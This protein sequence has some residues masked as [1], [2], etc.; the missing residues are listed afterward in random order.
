MSGQMNGKI[1]TPGQDPRQAPNPLRD[2][3]RIIRTVEDTLHKDLKELCVL[4]TTLS[5]QGWI[6]GIDTAMQDSKCVLSLTQHMHRTIKDGL[7]VEHQKIIRLGVRY[8]PA[9]TLIRKAVA[10]MTSEEPQTE[11]T[12][13][14][15]A[16]ADAQD[17]QTSTSDQPNEERK[18]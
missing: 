14:S 11:T 15:N 1:I 17:S 12:P 3:S 18:H 6:I 13:E 5:Q 4:L 7:Q 16:G 8:Q 10:G 2:A 9:V